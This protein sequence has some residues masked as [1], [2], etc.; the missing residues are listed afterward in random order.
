MI[1]PSILNN[2]T[3]WKYKHRVYIR[4]HIHFYTLLWLYFTKINKY[5]QNPKSLHSEF[6]P[7]SNRKG[8]NSFI[9]EVLN[10]GNHRIVGPKAKRLIQI[11]ENNGS[12]C[13]QYHNCTLTNIDCL[14]D[15]FYL[16]ETR[17]T[18]NLSIHMH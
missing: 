17:I 9:W 10:I 5:L 11:N 7:C 4:A 18:N 15:E 1:Q 6:I 16:Q 14:Q 8:T 13:F 2:E 3:D 12:P